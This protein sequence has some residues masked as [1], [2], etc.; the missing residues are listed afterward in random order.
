MTPAEFIRTI[1]QRV[2]PEAIQDKET[3]F[4]FLIAGNEGGEFTITVKD[5]QCTE[6]DGLRGS[7]KCTYRTTA[8]VLTDIATGK[9]KGQVALAMGDVKV[10]NMGEMMKFAKIL[11]LD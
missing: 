1:P 4:H 11:G 10:D 3:C 5:G 9:K 7:P 8:S 2:N 6:Q